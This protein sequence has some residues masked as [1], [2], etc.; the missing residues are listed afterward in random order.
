MPHFDFIDRLRLANSQ[1]PGLVALREEITAGQRTEPWSI[2]DGL[3][4]FQERLFIPAGAA[5]LQELM[6]AVHDDGHEGVQHTLHR[7]RRDFH[8]PNLRAAVQDYVRGCVTCQRNKSEHL[9]PAGLLLPLPVPS[10]VWSDIGM[11]FIEALPRVAGKTVILT[12]VD[13]FSKYAHFVPLSHPYS[14]ESVAQAFFTEVVRLHGLPQSIVS[15]RDPVFTS[16]FWAELMRLSGIK[17]HMTSAFHP[18]SD[19][20]TEAANKVI[21]MYLRCLTGDRPR[22]WLRWLPWAEYL[23]NTAFQTALKTTPFKIVY[24]RDPPTIRSYEQGDSR[25]PAVAQSMAKRDELLADARARLE[26]A[27]DVYKRQYDKHHRELSFSVGD[28]AWLRL[29]HRTP[30]SLQ[31]I[32][33]GKLRPRFYGPYR[34]AAVINP[35]AYRLEL[36]PRARLHDVFHVGLLKRFVGKPPTSPPALPPIHNGATLPVPECVTRSRLAR[37]VRQLLVHWQGEPAASASWEDADDFQDRYPS[38]QLEDELLVKGGRDVMWGRQYS[39]RLKA[40]AAAGASSQ[41]AHGQEQ[42]EEA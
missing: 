1:D 16:R 31:G 30:S 27:Q 19:G 42:A 26:Q 33:K 6:S 7:I 13:R 10:S 22:Q 17:L 23:Y 12:I 5:L 40:R 14:A 35:V 3:V 29:R 18:Q 9:H 32:T 34:V 41:A 24:G 20:Q 11:D 38:F 4:A 28:W 21:V 36:P 2:I 8:S 25:V 15:D 39:R 37:G